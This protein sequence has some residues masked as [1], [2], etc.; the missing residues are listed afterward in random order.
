MVKSNFPISSQR[1]GG[2][3]Q[4]FLCALNVFGLFRKH[5]TSGAHILKTGLSIKLSGLKD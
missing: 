3:V 1:I 4:I 5:G 2:F